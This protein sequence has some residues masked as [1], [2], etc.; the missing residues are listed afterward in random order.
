MYQVERN[1][2]RKSYTVSVIF[3]SGLQ[4]ITKTKLRQFVYLK[5]GAVNTET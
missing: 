3:L 4:V 5:Q 1:I 2:S